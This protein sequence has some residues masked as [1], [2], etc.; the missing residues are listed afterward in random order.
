MP[1]WIR[2][3]PLASAIVFALTGCGQTESVQQTD[4]TRF[5]EAIK[6]YQSGCVTCHGAD[7]QGGFGPSLQH[8]ASTLSASEITHKIEV[9]GGPMPG[10]GPSHQGILTNQQIQ[11]LTAWLITKK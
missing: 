5:P 6:L 11:S 1:R 10:F 4:A 9:G 8:V 3:L 7:L 2:I